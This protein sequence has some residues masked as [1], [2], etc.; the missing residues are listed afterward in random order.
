MLPAV[1]AARVSALG[2]GTLTIKNGSGRVVIGAKGG[3]IGRFDEG[4]LVLIDLN[5]T[6]DV[7]AVVT[8]W[9]KRTPRDEFTTVYTGKGIRFRFIGGTFKVTL[10]RPTTGIDISAVGKG[11]VELHGAGNLDDGTYSFN[12]D[13]PRPL[14][15]TVREFSLAASPSP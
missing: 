3:V 10:T 2:D 1:A 13:A 15:L 9:E 4:T 6:D 5:P 12:G 7:D 11:T 14:P 8:G